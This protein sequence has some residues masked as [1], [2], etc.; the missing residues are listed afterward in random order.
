[1]IFHTFK[2]KNYSEMVMFLCL[3]GILMVKTVRYNF[4]DMEWLRRI[5]LKSFIYFIKVSKWRFLDSISSVIKSLF[6]FLRFYRNVS[7]GW[8]DTDLE[9]PVWITFWRP[10]ILSVVPF[11]LKGRIRSP[12]SCNS[13]NICINMAC[14]H[15]I[16]KE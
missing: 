7:S 3:H 12:K 9:N 5:I 11:S 13:I 8:R 14:F 4:I 15:L 6:P 10:Q 2:H 16:R 1:M